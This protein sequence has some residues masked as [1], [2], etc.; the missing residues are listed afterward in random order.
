M[1]CTSAVFT[2]MGGAV[3]LA[4]SAMY[5]YSQNIATD[6]KK[7]L[8]TY[9]AALSQLQEERAHLIVKTEDMFSDNASQNAHLAHLNEEN[10]ALRGVIERLETD[11][12]LLMDEYKKTRRDAF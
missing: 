1:N 11:N 6:L 4:F 8:R 3:A 7:K 9:N 12:H 5:F 10:K 2:L